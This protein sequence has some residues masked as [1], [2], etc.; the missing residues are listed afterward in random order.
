MAKQV[1]MYKNGSLVFPQT[2]SEAVAHTDKN[3][4]TSKLSEFINNLASDVSTLQEHDIITSVSSTDK[5]LAV[6]SDKVLSSTIS[7]SYDSTAGKIYLYGKDTTSP[8]SEINVASLQVSDQFVSAV[9]LITTA[10]SGVTTEVPYIKI[11]FKNPEGTSSTT[12]SDPIRISV[13]DIFGNMTASD[14]KLSSSYTTGGA[15]T[16]GTTIESAISTLDAYAVSTSTRLS[17]ASTRI[18][19]LEDETLK[20]V[21]GAT[22]TYVKI[23]ASA[24]S[25][26]TQTL[27]PSLTIQ[28]VSGASSSAKGLAEASDVKSYVDSAVNTVYTNVNSSLN[29]INSSVNNIETT[30]LYGEEV[31]SVGTYSDELVDVLATT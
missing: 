5:V 14:L 22:G 26:N 20:S 13:K 19:S 30:F 7:L 2:I 17:D 31:S 28:S 1:K 9:E 12:K 21:S 6:S 23:E 27:T 24:K 25:N 8:I 10:E 15:V 4:T 11:S 16:A 18:K 29:I 3:S